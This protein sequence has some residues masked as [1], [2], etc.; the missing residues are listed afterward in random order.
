MGRIPAIF[1]LPDTYPVSGL[2]RRDLPVPDLSDLSIVQVETDAGQVAEMGECT[3]AGLQLEYVADA[4]EVIG[5]IPGISIGRR[6]QLEVKSDRSLEREELL[7]SSPTGRFEQSK[8]PRRV[9]V[10]G[11]KHR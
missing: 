4:A 8:N 9:A 3:T 11:A 6:V 10:R 7:T 2:G 5:G 1:E